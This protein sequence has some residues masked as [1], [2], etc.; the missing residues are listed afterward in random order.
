MTKPY[1]VIEQCE[2]FSTVMLVGRTFDFPEGFVEVL[3]DAGVNVLG[4]A[5]TARH[6]LLIAAQT[7]AD[8]ALIHP[9]LAGQRDGFELARSL[10]ET[11][12]VRSVM[13]SA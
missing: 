6:A 11:W 8:L 1:D 5:D 7:P 13:I 2:R 12:G 4:P 10:E 9:K 3:T